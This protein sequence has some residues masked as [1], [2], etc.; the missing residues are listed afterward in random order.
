MS[1]EHLICQACGDD[2]CEGECMERVRKALGL[3]GYCEDNW[4]DVDE[5]IAAIEKLRE[6]A[7]A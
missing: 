4:A 1:G 6:G 3:P 2:M 5:I 7:A